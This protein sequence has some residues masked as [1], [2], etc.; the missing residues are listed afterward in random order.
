MVDEFRVGDVPA[1]K[2]VNE[3][4]SD[5]VAKGQS[6]FLLSTFLQ[7]SGRNSTGLPILPIVKEQI[8]PKNDVWFYVLMKRREI[9]Q[10]HYCVV[11]KSS[12]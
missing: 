1:N 6:S 11:S 9:I 4:S 10:Q 8:R 3:S 5:C 12:K 7:D 2:E